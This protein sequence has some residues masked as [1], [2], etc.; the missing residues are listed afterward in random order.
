MKKPLLFGLCCGS[1]FTLNLLL[2][3]TASAT[4]GSGVTGASTLINQWSKVFFGGNAEHQVQLSVNA[5]WQVRDLNNA[6]TAAL[7]ATSTDS[8]RLNLSLLPSDV[9]TEA[10]FLQGTNLTSAWA[11]NHGRTVLAINKRASNQMIV[12]MASSRPP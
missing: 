12:G 1:F 8:S 2:S 7:S 5:P 10:P 3:A 6:G 11:A 9:K 4:T